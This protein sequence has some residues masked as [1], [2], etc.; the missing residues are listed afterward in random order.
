MVEYP[1]FK[2]LV[3]PDGEQWFPFF[4]L[5]YY[6]LVQMARERYSLWFWSIAGHRSQRLSGLSLLQAPP[7]PGLALT[8]SALYAA[9]AVHHA[10][11]WNAFYVGYLMSLGFFLAALLLTADYLQAGGG[12]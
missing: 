4:R 6:G 10:I 12:R 1:F 5:V 9:A 11:A 2:Y 8:L 7:E 3:V